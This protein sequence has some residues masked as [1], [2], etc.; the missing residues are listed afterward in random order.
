LADLV[1]LNGQV[2]DWW[3][4]NARSKNVSEREF[5]DDMVDQSRSACVTL[6]KR[7]AVL[8]AGAEFFKIPPL[9]V[10]SKNT[11]GAGDVFLAATVKAQLDG[12]ALPDAAQI[13]AVAAARHVEGS[14]PSWDEIV[15]AAK[16]WNA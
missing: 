12:F 6:G 7:G 3:S 8:R 10:T 5:L 14:E 13:A 11:N 16:Q 1:F 4:K 9:R 15:T 2:F